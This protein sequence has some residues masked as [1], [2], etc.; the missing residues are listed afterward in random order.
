MLPTPLAD[1]SPLGVW[2]LDP[3]VRPGWGLPALPHVGLDV[4]LISPGPLVSHYSPREQLVKDSFI[5][6]ILIPTSNSI[7]P[8]PSDTSILL[9]K[10]FP[11]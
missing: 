10:Y 1:E 5:S 3:V 8:L 11:N 7:L 6:P 2:L 9:V 4:F